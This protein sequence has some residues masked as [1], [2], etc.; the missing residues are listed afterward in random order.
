TFIISGTPHSHIKK[1]GLEILLIH[2][3][4]AG[5]PLYSTLLREVCQWRGRVKSISWCLGVFVVNL[6]L[7]FMLTRAL[8]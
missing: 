4:M 3:I 5:P 1:T 6:F 8:K 2:A 7:T